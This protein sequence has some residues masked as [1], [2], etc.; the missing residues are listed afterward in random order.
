M[1]TPDTAYPYFAHALA[2][3]H[4]ITD[5]YLALGDVPDTVGISS[6]NEDQFVAM[7]RAVI[8]NQTPGVVPVTATAASAITRAAAL[9]HQNHIAAVDGTDAIST[10]Q[11]V[12]DTVYAAGVVLVTPQT[13]LT[14]RVHVT[15]TQATHT[16]PSP[17][18]TWTEAITKWAEHLRGAREQEH[19]WVNT[20]R[21]Y[22]ERR[23]ALDWLNESE[24][25]YVLIDGPVATQNMLT[26]NEA[27]TLMHDLLA[28]GRAIGFIKNLSANPLL[29]AVGHALRPGEAFIVREWS[30]I[31]SDR[32]QTRQQ[33]ISDWILQNANDLVRVIYKIGQRAFAMETTAANIDL[34][35][36]ILMHDNQ[37]SQQ[38]DIPMLLQIADAHVR[39][40]FNGARARDEVIARYAAN[41]P[42]RLVSLT[43]ER[44][45]R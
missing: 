20:F 41:D 19:S 4:D 15:R 11:F 38:H 23:I 29:Y 27:R 8:D 44:S 21:E 31:L 18:A 5:S 36:A 16:Q 25:H 10:M 32:F 35:L 14:P 17:T 24:P 28:T 26:Q 42:S 9:Y 6:A 30:N 43:S 13:H 12:T 1:T 3:Q 39:T 33:H 37:G 34:G 7:I 45:F 2:G 22:H 40:N